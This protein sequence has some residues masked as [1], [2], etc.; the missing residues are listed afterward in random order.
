MAFSNTSILIPTQ[1]WGPVTATLDWCE[2]NYQ[3]SSYVA[4]VANAYSNVVTVGLAA[5]LA[6]QAYTEALPRR[7]LAGY[8][9]FALVGI[10]SFIFHA[11]LTFEAQLADELPMIY[12]ASFCCGF[13]FDTG[14]GFSVRDSNAVPLFAFVICFNVLFT[15]SYY[16]SR[17]P[18][19]H[20]VVFACILLVTAIRTMILLRDEE[21]T[22]RLPPASKTL[23]ARTFTVGAATFAFGFFV[24]NL[25]N[26]FCETLTGW[27]RDIGWP[28]AFLMEGHSW[29]HVLTAAGTYLML[30]G[31][32]YFTLCIKLDH[33]DFA[34]TRSF[35]GVP[36]VSRLANKGKTQ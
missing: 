24:W 28:V 13:L 2:A 35:L 14:R 10:G 16:L 36:R 27:K 18:I 6:Y 9:G 34:I 17:N 29:W 3:F 32:T 12:V 23:V 4:E 25:D 8:T 21:V 5:Y 31:N 33:R 7:Y 20:Q 26:I 19:Y 11:T 1:F 22:R 30:V 15:W